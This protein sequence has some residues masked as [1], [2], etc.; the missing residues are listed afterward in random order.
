MTGL[1][2]AF[3]EPEPFLTDTPLRYDP[4]GEWIWPTPIALGD[5]VNEAPA[6]WLLYYSPHDAPAGICLASAESLAGPWTEHEGNPLIG[7]EW[8]PH[9]AVSH[10]ASPHPLWL[11]DENRMLLYFHGEN[12]TTRWALSENGVDFEYGDVALDTAA[13]DD[14]TVT[15]VSYARVFAHRLPSEPTSR[16]V[17]LMMV[18]HRAEAP[19][20]R[21]MHLAWSP[22]GRAWTA[23]QEPVVSPPEGWQCCG[24]QLVELGG[25]RCL[26]HHMDIMNDEGHVY[27]TPVDADLRR[28]AQPQRLLEAGAG[29]AGRV[30][31]PYLVEEDGKRYLLYISGRRLQGGFRMREIRS[32]AWT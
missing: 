15:E 22:D 14:P 9:Y 30:A 31:D 10:V 24:G 1:N 21:H 23:R 5:R 26:L 28:V 4:T 3:G 29:D 2:A 7:R 6:K 25:R 32:C 18:N 19:G 11:E 20:V 17:M 13:F 12:G 8:P 27:A 16:F